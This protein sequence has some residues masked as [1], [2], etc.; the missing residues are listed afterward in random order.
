MQML[1]IYGGGEGVVLCKDRGREAVICTQLKPTL[2]PFASALPQS[3]YHH[4]FANFCN[5]IVN[6]SYMV[7]Y[8]ITASFMSVALDGTCSALTQLL[9][10]AC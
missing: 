4:Y 8:S 9:Q 3:H 6:S 2:T 1:I 10:T 5:F 7:I